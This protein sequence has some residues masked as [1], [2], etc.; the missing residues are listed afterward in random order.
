MTDNEHVQERRSSPEFNVRSRILA[1]ID[2]TDDKNQRNLLLLMFGVLESNETG[3]TR[4]EKKLDHVLSDEKKLRTAVLNGHEPYHHKHHDWIENRIANDKFYT[5]F[6][7]RTTHTNDWVEAYKLKAHETAPVCD[8]AKRKM[9][10]E[11]EALKTK[12]SVIQKFFE[13]MSGNAGAIIMA[14][15]IGWAMAQWVGK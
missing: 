9:S 3:L 4:I 1:A 10:E 5:D 7:A 8:W 15:T 14:G 2:S 11:D 6:I 12:K 13:G